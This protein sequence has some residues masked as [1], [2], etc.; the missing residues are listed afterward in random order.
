[1]DEKAEHQLHPAFLERIK[2]LLEDLTEKGWDLMLSSGYRTIE[3][4]RALP[5]GR[6]NT[7]YSFHNV[8]NPETGQPESMAAHVTDRRIGS[9]DK[10]NDKSQFWADLNESVHAHGMFTGYAWRNPDGSRFYEGHHV[11]LYSNAQKGEVERGGRPEL[12]P[13]AHEGFPHTEDTDNDASRILLYTLM[14]K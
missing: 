7:R 6:S 12:L 9:H 4:Q 5:P 3:E 14:I 8:T 11:Q 2:C 1:M 10:A 13:S